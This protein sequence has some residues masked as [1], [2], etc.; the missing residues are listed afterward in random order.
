[1]VEFL[2]DIKKDALYSELTK[3]SDWKKIVP[4]SSAQK[5]KK[6]SVSD[7]RKKYWIKDGIFGDFIPFRPTAAS[8]MF[9]IC[10]FFLEGSVLYCIG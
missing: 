3:W 7:F 8:E 5:E 2:K 9:T 6:I 4:I 10:S 1:M